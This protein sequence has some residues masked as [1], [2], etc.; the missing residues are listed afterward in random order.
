VNATARRWITA[1]AAAVAAVALSTEAAMA[2]SCPSP[3]R[4]A[5]RLVLVTARSMNATAAVLRL[6]RRAS[7]GA[8]WRA[9]GGPEPAVVGKAGMAWSPFF[10]RLARRGEPIKVEGDKRAPAGVFA[11]GRSFGIL[12]SSRPGYL[13]ITPGTVCVD[14]PRSAAYNTITLRS[15]VGPSVHAENMSRVR[16]LYRRGLLVNYPT[17]ARRRAGSCI[18]I[19]V[20]GSASTGTAGCVAL[21]EPRVEALQEF[22]ADGAVLAILPR[23]A[24]GRLRGCLPEP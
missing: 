6:Y 17:D 5:R 21:P 2:Q 18:F 13:R 8:P 16:P 1:A 10:R 12:A 4:D 22:A 19:H 11:L 20:W 7:P 3:L 24:L 15:R 23:F 9:L 14:D